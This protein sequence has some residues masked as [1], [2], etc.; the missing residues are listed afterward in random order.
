VNDDGLI[1]AE[2]RVLLPEGPTPRIV[3][4]INLGLSWKGL[5]LNA[6][7][8]GQDGAS[9]IYRPWD[10]NQDD[11]YFENRWIS[12]EETPNA[13]S[14]AAWDMSSST[15]Q[16]VST[17]WVKKNNFLRIKNVELAY[18]LPSE[19]TDKLHISN[20]RL[21]V[22]AFNLGF[23]FDSVKLYDPESRSDTGWYYPQQRMFTTGLS[24]TF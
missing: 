22:S 3:Y 4:G 21:F 14:P 7:F 5:E 6:F 24:V 17:I 9:T 12:E 1:N 10:I 19:I 2:D 13:E 8:Q 23:I 11:W 15:I 16:N 20:V 18:T